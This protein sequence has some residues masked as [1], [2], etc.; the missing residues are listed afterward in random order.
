MLL[1]RIASV[2]V[3]WDDRLPH[4][5]FLTSTSCGP[6]C[7]GLV[8]WLDCAGLDGGLAVERRSSAVVPRRADLARQVVRAGLRLL[9]GSPA[10]GWYEEVASRGNDEL[11]ACVARGR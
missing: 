3:R 5:R 7:R 8:A 6:C 9:R 1:R 4:V 10:S 11:A 2:P